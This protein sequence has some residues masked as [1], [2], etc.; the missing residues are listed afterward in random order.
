MK[1]A[2][3]KTHL[4]SWAP[5]AWEYEYTEHALGISP[6]EIPQELKASHRASHKVLS[7]SELSKH[8]EQSRQV[9]CWASTVTYTDSHLP[10]SG[11]QNILLHQLLKWRL[12]TSSR[13]PMALSSTQ[14]AIL[15]FVFPQSNVPAVNPAK[16][17]KSPL[18][19]QK[20]QAFHVTGSAGSP[21][22]LHRSFHLG[23]DS[24]PAEI[25]GARPCDTQP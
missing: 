10:S 11:S 12:L 16:M 1:E 21:D 20:F 2:A 7:H 25:T 3:Q 24:K 5:G 17:T 19:S 8:K 13:P 14:S 9:Q 4:S 22:L 6:Q 23:L 15:L 18:S